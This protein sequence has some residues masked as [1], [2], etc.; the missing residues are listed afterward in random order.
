MKF[1]LEI[2]KE[3]KQ[4]RNNLSQITSKSDKTILYNPKKIIIF[5]IFQKKKIVNLN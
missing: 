2:L 5:C 3:Q 1:E 4:K